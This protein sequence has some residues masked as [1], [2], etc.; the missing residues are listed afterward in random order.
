MPHCALIL[1]RGFAYRYH[2]CSVPRQAIAYASAATRSEARPQPPRA[3]CLL[4]TP[5]ARYAYIRYDSPH[6]LTQ[7]HWPG[8]TVP[9]PP[10]SGSSFA[11]NT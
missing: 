5:A 11:Q 3:S 4:H 10:Q 6:S 2:A 1:T 7:V 9:W 8:C